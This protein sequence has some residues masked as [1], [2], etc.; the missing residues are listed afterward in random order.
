MVPRID[1][2]FLCGRGVWAL[3]Q[4]K[5]GRVISS[6]KEDGSGNEEMAYNQQKYLI[7]ISLHVIICKNK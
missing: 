1:K 6:S 5:D 2:A 3:W 7:S 4:L